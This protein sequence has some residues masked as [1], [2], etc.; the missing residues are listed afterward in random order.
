MAT[1]TQIATSVTI[2]NSLLGFQGISLTNYTT[3]SL[4]SISQGSKL[5]CAGAFFK[6]DSNELPN[7]SSWTAIGIATT[8]YL[9]CSPSGTAGSQIISASWTSTAPTWSPTK[10][11]WYASAE[12]NIR[13]IGSAYKVSA[14]Q[15]EAKYLFDSLGHNINAGI[16]TQLGAYALAANTTGINN[17]AV[18]RD[19]LKSNTEGLANVAVGQLALQ[20]NTTGTQNTAVG[21][22]SLYRNTIGTTNTAIGVDAL[23]NNINGIDNTAVGGSALQLNSSGVDNTAV[24]RYCMEG[25]T[26]GSFNSALGVNA[27]IGNTTG[28]KNSAVGMDCLSNLTTGQ[29][30]AGLGYNAQPSAANVNNEITLGD[31]NIATLRCKVTVITAISDKRDKRD[32]EPFALGYEFMKACSGPKE[33]RW[34]MREWYKDGK[35]DGSKARKERSVG[36]IAQELRE[37]QE[38]FDVGYLNLVYESNP[39]KLEATPGNL[40]PVMW[41]AILELGKKVEALEG[42]L[43]DA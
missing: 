26:T 41:N 17:V 34:D 22:E 24:G 1:G 8:C 31:A 10:Q 42:R 39:D 12:S 19:A 14:T 20:A 2:L 6:W 43:R 38:K 21:M 29:N 40:L 16:N 15:Q 32:I 4:S 25:N 5:E 37:A 27:L 9:Q 35:S 36:W 3:S 11:G 18:G 7:A 30:C 33:F 23:Y 13:V 28:Q